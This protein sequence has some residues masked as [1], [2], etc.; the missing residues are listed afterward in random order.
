MKL[1]DVEKAKKGNKE[2]FETIIMEIIDSLYKVA[3][4]ILEKAAI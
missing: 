2:A 1:E 4:G 3:Y